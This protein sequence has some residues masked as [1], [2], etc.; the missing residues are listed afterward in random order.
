VRDSLKFMGVLNSIDPSRT[1]GLMMV[2]EYT[3]LPSRSFDAIDFASAA[4]VSI[5]L[6][7]L[8]IRGICSLH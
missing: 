8:L 4:L 5:G 1:G 3:S 7:A 2:R 6:W